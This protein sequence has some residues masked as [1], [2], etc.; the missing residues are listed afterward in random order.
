MI[1]ISNYYRLIKIHNLVT[2]AVI[3]NS[4][5]TSTNSSV[6]D[7]PTTPHFVTLTSSSV[8]STSEVTSDHSTVT[9]EVST[10]TI[11]SDEGSVKMNSLIF[12]GLRSHAYQLV[13]LTNLTAPVCHLPEYPLDITHGP[14]AMVYDEVAGVVRVCGG[15][16]NP[17]V[18]NPDSWNLTKRCFTFDGFA[19]IEMESTN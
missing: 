7:I 16:L 19:W 8:P 3:L 15:D 11:T 17:H 9:S 6:T 18:G 12:G 2:L 4:T 1:L 14:A 10:T 13:D 5:S